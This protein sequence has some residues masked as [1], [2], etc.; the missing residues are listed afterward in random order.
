M[1]ADDQGE[2]VGRMRG[3]GGQDL[4]QCLG[5]A[6]KRRMDPQ[7]VVAIQLHRHQH[8][9]PLGQDRVLGLAHKAPRPVPQP[10]C[11]FHERTDRRME[12]RVGKQRRHGHAQAVI[13]DIVDRAPQE[14]GMRLVM[15]GGPR[16]LAPF[17]DMRGIARQ[18]RKAVDAMGL[19]RDPAGP[20]IAF[21]EHPD[22]DAV[23]AR[24]FGCHEMNR[25]AVA[26][27]DDRIRLVGGDDLFEEGRQ[28]ALA[29]A[30]PCDIVRKDDVAAIESNAA[31][32]MAGSPERNR[33]F[34][35]ERR[36][37]PLQHQKT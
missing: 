3:E 11:I 4:F 23:R 9:R 12:T 26:E 19:Q 24:D 30:K 34:G 29:P 16:C 10:P 27:Q 1:A 15:H 22:G 2:R 28:G 25:A 21:L 32:M 31:D 6:A 20:E 35:K 17:A 7:L 8:E 18:G 33:Q 36:G 5:H 14:I 13:G 37:I